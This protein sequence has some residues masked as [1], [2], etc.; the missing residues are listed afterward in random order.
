MA[1]IVPS[2]LR[3]PGARWFRWEPPVATPLGLTSPL[4]VMGWQMQC[5]GVPQGRPLLGGHGAGPI[6]LA[7]FWSNCCFAWHSIREATAAAVVEM[8]FANHQRVG[9]FWARA[10]RT[11]V[12]WSSGAVPPQACN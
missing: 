5:R 2:L 4:P 11:S 6:G 9:W 8:S 12:V 10:L 7:V 3:L 1:Y